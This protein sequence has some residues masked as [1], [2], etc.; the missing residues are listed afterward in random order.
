[1]STMPRILHDH[2]TGLSRYFHLALDDWYRFVVVR[3]VTLPPGFNRATT[4]VLIE[5]LP[6]YP[7]TPPGAG[8]SRVFVNAGLR[9]RGRQLVDYHEPAG[10]KYPTPGFGPWAW[11]CYMDIHWNPFRDDLIRFIEMLRADLTNPP[12]HE[13]DEEY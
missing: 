10:T 1:M 8:D 6:D 4:D 12:T 9:F 11:L 13:D 2:L 3:G 5:F 7:V